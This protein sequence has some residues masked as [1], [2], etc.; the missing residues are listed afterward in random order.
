M[1]IFIIF[2]CKL[3]NSSQSAYVIMPENFSKF[4]FKAPNEIQDYFFDNNLLAVDY[5]KSYD[6]ILSN[7]LNENF[8]NKFLFLYCLLAVLICVT[9][10][11]A[12]ILMQMRTQLRNLS[13]E[14]TRIHKEE[15]I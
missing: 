2:I 6:A 10:G 11:T 12:I 15:H 7:C 13:I 5:L 4:L 3:F 8:D 9:M 14:S 1:K